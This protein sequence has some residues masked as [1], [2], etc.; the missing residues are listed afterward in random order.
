MRNRRSIPILRG[1]SIAIMSIALVLIVIS[2]IGYSRQR[3]SYPRGMTIAG[4]PVGGVDPQTASERV[5]QVY[6]SP[7]EARYGAASIHI[8]PSDVGFELDMDSMIAAAELERTGGVFWSGFW[9]YLW[10]REPD[11]VEIL[12]K[13]SVDEAR[14]TD[15]LQN[16]IA[17]RYDEPPTP[18]QPIP[19]STS[20]AP[21]IPGRV[22]DIPRAVRLIDDTLRSPNNRVVSLSFGQS[23]I[24][25]PT[26]DNLEILLKQIIT[27]SGFDGVIGLYLLDLQTGQEI[28][29]ALDQA[30]E[31]S[32]QPDVTFTASSTIK[33]PILVSY[34]IKNGS[35]PV[36]EQTQAMINEMIRKSDNN[37]SD[38]MMNRIDPNTGPLIITQNMKTIGLEDTFLAGFFAPGSPLLQT[39][40]TPANSREDVFTD[41]DSYNQTTPLDMGMLLADL[42]QCATSGGGALI[43]AF[44][45]KITSQICQQIIAY[46]STDKIG[47]LIEAGVPE[48]TQIAHKHGWITSSDGVIRNFSDASIVY[49]AGGNFVLSI[50]AYHP[51]QIV[52]D[53]ANVLFADLGAAV[54]NFYNLPTP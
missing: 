24:A 1:I 36:D 42:Y 40:L 10:N 45:E 37:A 52:F 7:V 46:L 19:G 23:T 30:Q 14:L 2:L 21:S 13:A 28:H 38:A 9:N 44:P 5:L 39:F 53:N 49:T 27:T 12:L 47:V 51:I 25:R 17:A 41:P 3:N 4:V 8:D 29:F 26:M 11:P 31:I 34:Y 43:A 50:Y 54:Y 48:G 20:F 22:L 16:E 32:V 18:A 35:A 33:I 6:S 15:Y